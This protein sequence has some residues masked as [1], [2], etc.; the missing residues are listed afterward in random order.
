MNDLFLNAIV[1]AGT[2]VVVVFIFMLT[3]R[4]RKRQVDLIRSL[5][6]GHG[7]AFA[8]IRE[9][10]SSGFRLQSEH[11][12]L[13]ALTWSSGHS[14][15]PSQSEVNQRT[16]LWTEKINGFSGLV[17]IGP[18]AG[19]VP[20]LGNLGRVMA[21]QIIER[22]IGVPNANLQN[23]QTGSSDFQKKYKVFAQ[24]ANDVPRILTP[25][26]EHQ[27]LQWKG[28]LPVIKITSQEMRIELQGKHC[29]TPSDILAVTRLAD[30]IMSN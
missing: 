25:D 8:E 1:I 5:A 29:K 27:L 11:W 18:W 14:P 28:P 9:R 16:H 15:E 20:D 21:N 7:W 30:G 19:N 17:L 4:V 2:L 12:T 23:I 13:E 24:G 3:K 6:Q 10:L 22:Y 26:V